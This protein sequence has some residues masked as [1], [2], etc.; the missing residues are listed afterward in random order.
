MK[1]IVLFVVTNLAILVVLNVVL[2]VLERAGVFGQS[3]LSR[4][5]GPLMVMSALFLT[6]ATPP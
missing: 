4:Q 1:R 2:A 6:Q 3:G 5:Y